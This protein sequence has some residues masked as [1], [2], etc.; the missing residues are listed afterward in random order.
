MKIKNISNKVFLR[1]NSGISFCYLEIITF[2]YVVEILIVYIL[3]KMKCRIFYIL[4][5]YLF[6]LI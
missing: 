4:S 1:K 2:D 5:Q 6:L 3:Y